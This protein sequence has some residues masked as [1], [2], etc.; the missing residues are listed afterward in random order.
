MRARDAFLLGRKTYDIFAAH[1]PRVTDEND[2]VATQLNSLPKYVAS[3]TLEKAEWDNSTVI[4][5][6]AAEVAKLK[7]QPG[8][9]LQVHGSG[10]LAQTC[11]STDSWTNI[12]YSS[13][14]SSWA[15]VG[16]SSPT[17]A[18]PPP[19]GWSKRRP[20][21]RGWSSAP[22]YR[23]ESRSTARSPLK[24]RPRSGSG[25]PRPTRRARRARTHENR[26]LRRRV[27][28]SVEA[29]LGVVTVDRESNRASRSLSSSPHDGY[30]STRKLRLVLGPTS[31]EGSRL[32][33]DAVL[34]VGDAGRL[35]RPYLLDL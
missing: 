33:D 3:R 29:H 20:P 19:C 13:T 9:E 22:T 1:W 2:P 8:R 6:V 26:V 25:R 30:V 18:C 4:S 24:T 23:R 14:R 28:R 12:A 16:G 34:D 15:V 32:F 17:E 10:Q 27:A 7:R 31:C 35:D 11:W 5:D 21:A